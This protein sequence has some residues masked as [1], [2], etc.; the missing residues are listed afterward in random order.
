MKR[1][2]LALVFILIAACIGLVSIAPYAKKPSDSA[3][4]PGWN[5]TSVL[6]DVLTGDGYSVKIVYSSVTGLAGLEPDS[7]LLV[8]GRSRNYSV[9]EAGFIEN[10]VSKGG[11][12]I[13]ADK[14][15]RIS[16][17]FSVSYSEAPLV[18]YGH[19]N[20]RQDL[21]VVPYGIL[22]KQGLLVLK[23]PHAIVD[24]PWNATV[25]SMSSDNSWLDLNKDNEI[26]A[27]LDLRGP[28]PV[29]VYVKEGK[30]A[31]VFISDQSFLTNDMLDRGD[32]AN[33]LKS[34]VGLLSADGRR[35]VFLDE[36]HSGGEIGKDAG[37]ILSSFTLA[38][39][40]N[41]GML[42]ALAVFVSLAYVRYSI[43]SEK[44]RRTSLIEPEE[45]EYAKLVS[46]IQGKFK[47]RFEPYNWVVIMRYKELRRILM[48]RIQPERR[49]FISNE[50]LV[51]ETYQI[52]K[53]FE[54]E[55]LLR[56]MNACEKIKNGESVVKT[57]G[58][59]KFL[60]KKIESYLQ[61]I[62]S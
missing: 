42:Y 54:R 45:S 17:H 49:E 33:Y 14:D 4:N 46:D 27:S 44:N 28:F 32:N 3:F 1:S 19:Y 13:V 60:E 30:G 40:I 53:N 34:V 16:S 58:E 56:L 43:R 47:T 62:K 59:T 21:P 23:F 38:T 50:Q 37:A 41:L 7:I 15:N 20:K 6:Y 55:D 22:G 24:R 52:K 5:G 12:I 8:S 51:S 31:A 11:R 35:I 36:S 9:A 2:T 10:Y 39:P 26:N 57:V 61:K 48:R 18:D 25:L 29:S